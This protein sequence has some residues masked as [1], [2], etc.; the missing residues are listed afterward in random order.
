MEDCDVDCDD[1]D[2]DGEQK[3][4]PLLQAKLG[5]KGGVHCNVKPCNLARK[6]LGWRL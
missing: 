3:Q 1:V 2:G 4:E 6:D 5:T